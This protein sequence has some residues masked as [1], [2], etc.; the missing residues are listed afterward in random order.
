MTGEEYTYSQLKNHSMI[1]GKSLINEGLCSGDVLALM[2]PNCPQ[3]ISILLG[4]S[5]RGITICGINPLY[6][7]G[8][9]QF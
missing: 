3:F 6:T 1:V 2:L 8:K 4:A 9:F 5:E 7:A